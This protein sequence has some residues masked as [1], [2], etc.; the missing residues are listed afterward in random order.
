M[1]DQRSSLSTTIPISISLSLSHTHTHIYI[2]IY[3]Y[4]TFDHDQT[5]AVPF[6]PSY[7]SSFDTQDPCHPTDNPDGYIALCVAENKLVTDMLVDRFTQDDRAATAF[8]SNEVYGYTNLCGLD[9]CREAL[10]QFFV[11][12]FLMPDGKGP[13][14]KEEALRHI[15]ADQVAVASG[16]AALL[17][18]VFFL[19][20]ED[21][22]ACLIPAPYYAAFENDINV[23]RAWTL[24]PLSAWYWC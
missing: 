13:L 3:I 16:C 21:G 14:S 6:P 23:S 18:H 15:S 20:G 10:A 22:D 19:L 11:Q 4:I 8:A 12:R 2:Y 5:I 24:D 1:D 9:T 17:T 7:H